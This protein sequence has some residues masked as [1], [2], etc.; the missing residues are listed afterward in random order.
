MKPPFQQRRAEEEVVQF[1]KESAAQRIRRWFLWFAA[2]LVPFLLIVSISVPNL[3]RSRMAANSAQQ[4]ARQRAAGETMA[5]SG[6][7]ELSPVGDLRKIVA[8]GSLSLIV[9]DV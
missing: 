7:D 9:T 8:T 4:Y 3:L 6:R 5:A 1:E 2:G